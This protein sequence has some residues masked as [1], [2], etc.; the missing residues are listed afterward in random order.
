MR[1][2]ASALLGSSDQTSHVAGRQ[3]RTAR[4]IFLMEAP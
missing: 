3:W 4:D 1:S 2:T